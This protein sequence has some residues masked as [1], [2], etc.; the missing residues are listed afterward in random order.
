MAWPEGLIAQVFR[1]GEFERV[2]DVVTL[3]LVV[4]TI[5]MHLLIELDL[6][7]VGLIVIAFT[8]TAICI[9]EVN[10]RQAFPDDIIVFL[11]LEASV[12]NF[13]ACSFDILFFP[14]SFLV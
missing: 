9:V 4:S 2:D 12:V 14:F 11:P 10:V 8:M 6:L 1:H 13:H 3:V 5:Q 7:L